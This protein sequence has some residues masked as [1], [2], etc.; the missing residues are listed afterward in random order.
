MSCSI[1]VAS[2]LPL[3]CCIAHSCAGHFPLEQE[4]KEAAQREFLEELGVSLSLG[5][6]NDAVISAKKEELESLKKYQAGIE[7]GK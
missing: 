6:F 2:Y 5:D 7:A 3:G 1:R 4:Y